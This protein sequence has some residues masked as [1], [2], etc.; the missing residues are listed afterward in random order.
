MK[1]LPTEFTKWGDTFR[2]IKREGD[3]AIYER[4]TGSVTSFE[5]VRIRGHN[6]RTFADKETGELR[7]TDPAEYYPSSE[8][9]GRMGWTYSWIEDAENKMQHLLTFADSVQKV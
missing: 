7:T 1:I 3:I 2:Q 9:W 8:E 6:G 4:K 5:V